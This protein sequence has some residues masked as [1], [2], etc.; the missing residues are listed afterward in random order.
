MPILASRRCARASSHR[1]RVA[2]VA[3][4]I[5][6]PVR[7]AAAPSGAAVPSDDVPPIVAETSLPAD[8][9]SE[10]VAGD[11]APL[12]RYVESHPRDRD[13]KR[14]LG[15]LEVRAGEFVRAERTYREILAAAPGDKETHDRLGNLDASLDRIDDAI[16]E[17][18]NALPDVAAFADLV[19]AHKRAGDLDAFVATYRARAAGDPADGAAQFAYGVVLRELHQPATAL[20]FLQ[21]ALLANPRSCPTLTEIGNVQLDLGATAGAIGSFSACLAID[22]DDYSAMVDLGDA[23]LPERPAETR[24]LLDRAVGLRP[25][26]PE[27]F[28][29]LGYLE[30]AAGRVP[31]A[32][33]RYEHAL[34]LDPFCRDAYVDLGF[35]YLEQSSFTTAD[36]TFL[37]G[38]SV[39]R[40][41]GRLEYLLGKSFERQGKRE[42]AVREYRDATHSDEPEV[43]AAAAGD[44]AT[45]H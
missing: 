31:N 32:I 16:G 25:N 24:R 42:L 23:Y 4:A 40:D 11:R 35:A 20:P 41:D 27:A 44:L 22:P 12:E 7:L 45:F 38:L 39:S 28:V 18:E 26:R 37:R 10:A 9:R 14:F 8:V 5:A 33:A 34:L 30:D 6:L 43:A 2:L 3:A 17:F 19:R 13:A 29:N 1:A 15:D 36:A 21:A